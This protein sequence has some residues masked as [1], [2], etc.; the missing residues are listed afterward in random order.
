MLQEAKGFDPSETGTVIMLF[1]FAGIGGM[2]FAGWATDRFFGGKAPYGAQAGKEL[3]QFG[4]QAGGK[5]RHDR[6]R[7]GCPV[8][9][10][11]PSWFCNCSFPLWRDSEHC[12]LL[13]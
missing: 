8:K 3:A 10:R 13:S 2:L 7:R 1:E 6:H 11:F 12:P 4:M 5:P 9:V